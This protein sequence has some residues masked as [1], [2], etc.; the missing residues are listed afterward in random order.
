MDKL[1]TKIQPLREVTTLETKTA[2][3]PAITWHP[4][5]SAPRPTP[6]DEEGTPSSS[7]KKAHRRTLRGLRPAS[8]VLSK[9]FPA[10]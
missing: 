1:A 10:N 2:Q 4:R 9:L 8:V 5:Y 3:S 6:L 7:E